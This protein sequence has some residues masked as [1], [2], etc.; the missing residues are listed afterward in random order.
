[1]PNFIDRL[2]EK[3]TD[4]NKKRELVATLIDKA[5]S[6]EE[7][8]RSLVTDHWH[9]PLPDFG[10]I[11]RRPAYAVDGSRAVRHLANGAYL[12]VAQA[13]IVGDCDGTRMEASDVDL[14][15]LPGNTDTAVVERYA[16][17][18]MHHL[19]VKLA[20]EHA[21][22]MPKDSVI[23]LDGALYGQLSSLYPLEEN[24]EDPLPDD[25]RDLPQ[26]IV[27]CYTELFNT[28]TERNLFLVSV[29]KTSH[30][31]MHAR[32]WWDAKHPGRRIP[33]E[34]SD[35]ELIYRWTERKAG[36]STPV[37]FGTHAEFRGSRRILFDYLKPM[38][39]IV[40]FFVRLADY[41]DALRVDVP[42]ICLGRN[43]LIGDVQ[44]PRLT[45]P[46]EIIP[47]LQVLVADY[48]GLEVYNVMLYSVDHEVRLHQ[49]T[50]DEI[51][52]S[53]IQSELGVPIPLDRSE[54]RFH[55]M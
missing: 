48:G 1:M 26:T 12:F 25:V 20:Q 53:I 10:K 24:P 17:L 15:I 5:Q 52:V 49:A 6:H 44:S 36:H 50:M 9:A 11:V 51:Y 29:A 39:A 22:Q 32:V 34:I 45:A 43:E 13:L 35:T 7:A 27:G 41:D 46:E 47:A 16:G 30:E 21:K 55:S 14:R 23:F 28:C 38:P 40:S 54:R 3:L 37:M 33:R 18:M 31:K 8:L 19:E 42:S 4:H 2:S